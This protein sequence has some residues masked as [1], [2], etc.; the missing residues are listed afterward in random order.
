MHYHYFLEPN[1]RLGN[2]LKLNL[3]FAAGLSYL[4]NPFD[5]LKNPYN[6]SYGYT[7]K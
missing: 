2:S 7:Y 6:H 3:R 5:S 1:Y 4:N